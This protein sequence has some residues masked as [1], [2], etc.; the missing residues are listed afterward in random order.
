MAIEFLCPACGATLRVADD[1]P[2]RMVRCGGCL[3]VLRVPSGPPAPPAESPDQDPRSPVLQQP[4]S[5]LPPEPDYSPR[6]RTVF[7]LVMLFGVLAV[8][9]SACCCGVAILMPAARWREHESQQGGFRVELPGDPRTN[10]SA[11]G[12]TT[13]AETKVVGTRLWGRE[14]VFLVAYEDLAQPRRRMTDRDQLDQ[15]VRV[16]QTNP[17][18]RVVNERPITV[19]GFPGR[20]IEYTAGR[21]ATYVLRLVVAEGRLYRVVAGGKSVRSGNDDVR[22]FLDSFQITD[23]KLL[24]AARERLAGAGRAVAAAAYRAAA[25]NLAE[26]VGRELAI[27]RDAGARVAVAVLATLQ[28]TQQEQRPRLPTAPA[29]RLKS[30]SDQKSVPFHRSLTWRGNL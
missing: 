28:H 8:G 23:P 9:L 12:I 3:S 25:E 1:V 22:R 17:T 30:D 13:G 20:E 18:V 26:A 7:W 11:P 27:L 4:V 24:A 19:S 29:P 10:V 6:R 21:N 5:P 2:G 15:A 14:E 16:L